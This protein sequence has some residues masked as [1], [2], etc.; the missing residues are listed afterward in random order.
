MRKSNTRYIIAVI[1]GLLVI[2]LVTA[3]TNLEK[4]PPTGQPFVSVSADKTYGEAP[5]SVSFTITAIPARGSISKLIIDYGDGT[6]EDITEN[7]KENVAYASHTYNSVGTFKVR[8]S[9]FD[10]NG[11]SSAE[12]QIITNDKPLVSNLKAY[13]NPTFTKEATDFMPYSDVYI[14][15]D[16]MDSQGIGYVMIDWG[17]GVKEQVFGECVGSHEYSKEGVYTIKMTVHDAVLNAPYPLT[18]TASLTINIKYGIEPENNPPNISIQAD[19]ALGE[20]PLEVTLYVGVSDPDGSISEV[21]VDWGDGNAET[22][23]SADQ[24]VTRNGRTIYKKTHIYSTPGVFT[25]TVIAKDDKGEVSTDT[26]YVYV[27]S[28]KPVL[29]VTFKDHLGQNPK[30]KTYSIDM[31]VY[32]K[33]ATIFADLLAYDLTPYDIVTVKK[34][35][36]ADNSTRIEIVRNPMWWTGIY[37]NDEYAKMEFEPWTIMN[38]PGGWY[39][40]GITV[41]VTVTIYALKSGVAENRYCEKGPWFDNLHECEEIIGRI[42]AE[43]SHVSHETKFTVKPE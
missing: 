35:D 6:Q 23:G 30:D 27:A 11:S 43:P 31:T 2:S 25:I 38:S 34:W 1:G 10:K 42:K 19:N 7:L 3:C 29:A 13:T 16:C 33:Q 8:V 12:L 32:E 15:A 24:I 39:P 36:Y 14:K 5:L 28:S 17:D 9:A 18:N 26:T 41:K 20:A 21:K 4:M 22:L 40:D 37:I